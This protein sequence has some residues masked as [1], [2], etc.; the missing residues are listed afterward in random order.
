MLDNFTNPFAVLPGDFNGDRVVNSQ[1]LVGIR[2][3][4]L[5]FGDP[6][7]AIWADVDGNGIVDINDYKAAQ[8]RVGRKL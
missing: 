5:G 6:A 7:F 4:I 8:K 2:N 3:Q 1:D